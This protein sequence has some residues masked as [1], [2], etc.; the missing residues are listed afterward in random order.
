MRYNPKKTKSVAWS[1]EGARVIAKD[2]TVI[3][4]PSLQFAALNGDYGSA[5]ELPS[6]LNM[7]RIE[8]GPR[9]NGVLE[10]LTFNKDYSALYTN[11]EEPYT[12]TRYKLLQK[13]V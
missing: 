7:Q 2:F 9:S 6:N 1:S 8:K 12:K 13:A 4:N 11:V 5:F 3:Q 10:G